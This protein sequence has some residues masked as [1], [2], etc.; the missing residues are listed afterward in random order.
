[1][2]LIRYLQVPQPIACFCGHKVHQCRTKA[3][4][5]EEVT[6]LVDAIPLI[7]V[8]IAGADGNIDQDEKDWGAKLTKI[9]SY[10]HPEN[11]N[12]FYGKVGETY[13]DRVE[14]LIQ[15][16][17]DD[18]DNRNTAISDRLSGLNAIL[19]KLEQDHAHKL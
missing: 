16:M 14:A 2:V 6:L 13:A 9:R 18:V 19:G 15:E 12:E 8:L 7:T 1:M 10:S 3:L 11:L 5:E 17:P 4:N